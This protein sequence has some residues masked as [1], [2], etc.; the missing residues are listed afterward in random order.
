[1]P[2][3]NY[4]LSHGAWSIW[5]FMK[6]RVKGLVLALSVFWLVSIVALPAFAE[7]FEYD[8]GFTNFSGLAARDNFWDPDT[9]D[10]NR[11]ERYGYTSLYGDLAVRPAGRLSGYV[12]GGLEWLHEFE[13]DTTD[14][15]DLEWISGYLKVAEDVF[16]ATAGKQPFQFGRG[17]IYDDDDLG[18]SVRLPVRKA[19]AVDVNAAAAFDRSPLVAAGLAYKPGFL[20]E[21]RVFAA[22]LQ[23]EE[24]GFADL[25][26]RNLRTPLF[27][28]DG[29]LYWAGME[30]D[31]FIGPI[32]FSGIAMAEFGS[33]SVRSPV[34]HQDFDV[35]AYLLDAELSYSLTP[36]LSAGG[37]CFLASGD[38]HPA[39]QDLH[40][41][42]SPYPYNDRT[43]IFFSGG[44][45]GQDITDGFTLAGIRWPGVIAPGFSL[46]WQINGNWLAEATA[47]AFFPEDRPS[48]NRSWYGWE[49]EG[50]I[51]YTWPQ[52]HEMELS[53]GFFE[54]GDM[55]EARTG[56]RPEAILAGGVWGIFVF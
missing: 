24:D 5:Q 20:E 30:A 36:E 10:F 52:G 33:F 6:C 3:K 50:M 28:G 16:S 42:I 27:S 12:S 41:F 35:S 34:N 9:R 56:K 55:F 39:S 2:K 43:D 15:L 23:D 53:L 18:L 38:K 40:A 31:R 46:F 19:W 26:N 29:R 32:Y 25:L 21:I 51:S 54:H 37:F 49:A 13:P 4:S 44:F 22:Y 7:S 17:L 47:A 8:Y 11:D 1:M 14:D 48:E 45:D